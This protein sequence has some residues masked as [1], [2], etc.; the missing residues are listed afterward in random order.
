MANY[1]DFKMI[2]VASYIALKC[3]SGGWYGW[4]LILPAITDIAIISRISRN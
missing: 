3:L 2:T 4:M 1:E